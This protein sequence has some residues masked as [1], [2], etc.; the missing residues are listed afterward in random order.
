MN[1]KKT[2]IS[3]A[4]AAILGALGALLGV[5]LSAMK[6]PVTAAVESSI[7]KLEAAKSEKTTDEMKDVKSV[8]P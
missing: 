1:M 8:V 5:D 4:V 7:E 6:Q 3:H 2:V